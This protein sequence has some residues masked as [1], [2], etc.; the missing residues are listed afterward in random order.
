LAVNDFTIDFT[1]ICTT[2]Q[3]TAPSVAD[4][5]VPLYFNSDRSFSAYSQ[6]NING[7]PDIFYI[8]NFPVSADPDALQFF[9]SGQDT[10]Q[11]SPTLVS[12]IGV[13]QLYITACVQPQFDPT[14]ICVDGPTF[15]VT[16][17]DICADNVILANS[18]N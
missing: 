16:V 3:L 7:C 1:D 17:W 6:N 4:Y 10:I 11:T 12:Q 14:A 15:Q 18:I 9:L 8:V 2:S 13:Y 5:D